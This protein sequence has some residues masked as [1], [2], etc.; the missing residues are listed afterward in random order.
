MHL[1]S[2]LGPRA[3]GPSG[4]SPA[5]FD[6]PT[7]HRCDPHCPC[8]R[9]KARPMIHHESLLVLPLMHHLVQQRVQRFFPSIAADVATAEHDL[10]LAALTRRTVVAQP[11][12]H[13]PGNADG[14]LA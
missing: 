1:S 13:A 12:P 8:L 5:F 4:L 3:L 14:N 10:R 2:P 6:R 9:P 7:S 11:A